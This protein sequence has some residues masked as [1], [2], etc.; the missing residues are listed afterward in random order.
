MAVRIQDGNGVSLTSTGAALDVNIKT[1]AIAQNV[2]VTNFPAT[3]PVSAVSL[4]LPSGASQDGVDGAGITGPTGGSGIRGWLSGI[5]KAL[6]GTLTTTVTGTVAVTG[7]FFQSTQPVSAASLPL[8]AN[9]AQE[10][11]GNL[12]TI[13]S[14]MTNGTQK[15]IVVN[16]VGTV[17]DVNAKGAQGAAFLAVQN[18]KDSGRTYVVLTL[19]SIAGV[20][21]EALATMTIN[22]AGTITTGTQ[23]TV[24]SGKTLRIQSVFL[25][26][27]ASAATLVSARAR[28]RSAA[29]VAVA[30]GS[31]ANLEASSNVALAG[32]ANTANINAPDGIEIASS[33]QVGISQIAS[34]TTALITVT[35]VGYEY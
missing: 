17:A 33:Q 14:A 4:P 26:V 21:T 6:V 2:S 5:Y 7:T 15:S 23:Y 11:G 16:S 18:A 29:T 25:S 32:A 13:A 19:D 10:S 22:K 28:I 24:T 20:T 31:I 34:A 9:A 30:S 8:P 1:S 27:R 3:Q 35:V 12:A